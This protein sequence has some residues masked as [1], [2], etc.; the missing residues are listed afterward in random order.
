MEGNLEVLRMLPEE[1]FFEEV[2][3]ITFERFCAKLNQK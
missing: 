1:S 2:Y 3:E